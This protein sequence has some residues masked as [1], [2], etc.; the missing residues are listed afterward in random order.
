[1][2]LAFTGNG[3][4]KTT[5]AI[6]NAVRIV[7]S[8]KRALMVQ[9]IKG[10]WASGEDKFVERVGPDFRIIKSGKG[11][12][13]ILGDTLPK[14]EHQKAAEEGLKIAKKEIAG[15]GWHLLILDEVH[16]AIALGLLSQTVVVAFLD[17]AKSKV[18]HIITTGRDAPKGI[19]EH[20]DLVT[21]MK[22]IKHPYQTGRF[23]EK[24]LDF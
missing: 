11:F 10:P 13:G 14:E 22:E 1:M 3:K 2:H 17:Y 5:A 6:G 23:A 7:G 4:G 15:G 8:G 20:A 18:E 24:G 12:V 16:N 9:F 19:I 21:E